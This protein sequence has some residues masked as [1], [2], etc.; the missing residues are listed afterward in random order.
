MWSPL[1]L[2]KRRKKNLN[3]IG[4]RKQSTNVRENGSDI[5][6]LFIYWF[7]CFTFNYQNRKRCKK[8]II[9]ILIIIVGFIRICEFVPSF[10]RPK[11]IYA[12][13][14]RSF[15]QDDSC[16]MSF[17]LWIPRVH[18]AWKSVK[19]KCCLILHLYVHNRQPAPP[20]HNLIDLFFL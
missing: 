18:L 15:V 8:N 16:R 14:R 1:A 10:S 13:V 6:L 11:R 4:K 7:Y 3:W 19:D 17:Y 9:I 12:H 5:F 20:S 2:H